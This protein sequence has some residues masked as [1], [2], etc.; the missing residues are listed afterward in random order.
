[1]VADT[2]SGTLGHLVMGTGNDNNSWGGNAN[3]AVFQILE[4]AIAN[5]LTSAVT[6]GTLDLSG[7]PPPAGASQTRY[8]ALVFTGT[9]VSNQIVI[10]PN[11]TKFWWVQNNTSGAFTLTVKTTAGTAVAVTQGTQL[12]LVFCNGSNGI[13]VGLPVTGNQTI[14]SGAEQAYAGISL[15]TGWLWEDGT[16]YDRA[17]AKANL[18]EAI[19]ATCTGNTNSNTTLNGLSVDLRGKGLEGAYIEGTGIQIGTTISVLASA[20]S[21]TLSQAATATATGVSIRVLPFG[22]GDGSTTFNVPDRRY[23]T[24]VGRDNMNNNAANRYVAI[25]GY[26]L[27]SAGG[28]ERHT[29]TVSEVPALTYS[30]NS[31]STTGTQNQLHSHTGTTNGDGAHTHT[32]SGSVSGTTSGQSADHA[33]NVNGS[34]GGESATHGHFIFGSAAAGPTG[35]GTNWLQASG[36]TPSGAN[37][38]DHSHAFNV[39][40]AGASVDHSHTWSGS[41]SGTTSGISVTHAHSFST[42][43]ES[44]IHTHGYTWAWSGSTSG[45]GASHENMPPFG[46][47]NYIIKL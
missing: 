14:P 17:G 24:L 21:I 19:T 20:T 34:T 3:T 46:I 9:L 29:L 32:Y 31:S 26:S 47:T 15:P 41:Y 40:S 8:A 38:T 30:G 18:F 11:L 7:S 37:T 25:A 13:T 42:G 43:T 45:G 44:G 1:M 27:A 12:Q 6:G 10:V 5:V 35:F 28:E 22:Q 16:A 4:D 23:R 36:E 33:H 2:Y 39:N